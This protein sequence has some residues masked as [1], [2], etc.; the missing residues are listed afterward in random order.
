MKSL[1]HMAALFIH[2]SESSVEP[3]SHVVSEVRG[4]RKRPCGNPWEVF[5]IRARRW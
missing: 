4:G 1:I 2:S 3:R 5:M